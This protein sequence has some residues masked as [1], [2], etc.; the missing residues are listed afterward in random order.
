MAATEPLLL[1]RAFI[2]C[3]RHTGAKSKIADSSGADLSGDE[4]L[5]R[6]LILRRLLRKHVL[7]DD[8][9]NV[10]VL[11]PP[12]TGGFL[13]NMA[14][15]LDR[16]VVTNVNYTLSAETIDECLKRAGIRQILTSQRVIEKLKL[17]LKTPL[18]MLE[19]LRA[20]VTWRDKAAGYLAGKWWPVQWLER[21]LGLNHVARDDLITIIFT[22]GSEG[23]PKGVMLSHYNIAAD[24]WAA[25]EGIHLRETDV[26]LGILPFFHS[27]GY[28]VTMWMVAAFGLKGVYHYSPLE[29]AQ[30]GKLCEK[31]HAT[32]L[33][34]TPTF[35]RSYI[36]R[37]EP[38]RFRS[39]DV[40]VAGAEKLRRD[41]ADAFEA[42]F[43]VRPVE[44][45]GATE[46]S[47]FVS[48]NVPPSRNKGATGP[49]LKEGTVGRP[50]TGFEARVIDTAT[51]K[52]LP[53]LSQGMLQIK[54]PIVMKGY[55]DEPE[56]TASVLRDGWYTTGDLAVIDED[57]FI[58]IQGRESR[59][60][61]I[62]GEMVPHGLIEARLSE[63]VGGDDNGDLKLAVTAVPDV[64]KGERLVVVHTSLDQSPE[65]LRRRLQ[66]SGMPPLFLPAVDSFVQVESLPV[67]G[68]GKL[69]LKGIRRIALQRFGEDA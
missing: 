58:E 20:K 24:V 53:T 38:E 56:K 66:E 51:G 40:V 26:L 46:L 33:A 9:T 65:A 41:L 55:L 69:D 45:Y 54:G 62:G 18:V 35:L 10:G 12:T 27:Y 63:L 21:S 47:P 42:R 60:S 13:V 31:H 59:F 1:P 29:P 61:K 3:C 50:L 39:L 32:I 43:G 4:T 48:V 44:G 8:E 36:K 6:S 19:D 30:I 49:T 25:I 37:V 52:P 34:A 67:L 64:K 11:M 7:V 22:S 57:G 15:A 5:I 16:R 14:L 23:V 2:R 68:S 28:T 17:D